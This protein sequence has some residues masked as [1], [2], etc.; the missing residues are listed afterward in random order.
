VDSELEVLSELFVELLIFL[1]I[2]TDLGDEFNALLGDVLL[3]DLED[4]VVLEE[5]SADVEG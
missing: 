4:L 2:L 5:L 1:S 3:D